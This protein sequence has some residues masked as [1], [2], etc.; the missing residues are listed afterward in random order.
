MEQMLVI[1]LVDVQVQETWGTVEFLEM[2][3]V[4]DDVRWRFSFCCS[5]GNWP[6]AGLSGA[7]ASLGIGASPFL[8]GL[9][10][11]RLSKGLVSASAVTRLHSSTC[12]FA[13]S[14]SSSIVSPSLSSHLFSFLEDTCTCA[15]RFSRSDFPNRINT[16][17]YC[18]QLLLRTHIVQLLLKL[19]HF[20]FGQDDVNLL[21]TLT[22]EWTGTDGHVLLT[23][24]A[25]GL[26]NYVFMFHQQLIFVSAV[27][28][29]S[30]W[31]LWSHIR[32]VI[33]FLF[34]FCSPDFKVHFLW[35]SVIW[36]SAIV[37]IVSWWRLSY[38]G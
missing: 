14:V 36:V 29:I 19:L 17:L 26:L 16:S 13:H 1:L 20:S 31:W 32:L 27:H 28:I 34:G 6:A 24:W 3:L 37:K 4:T 8:W 22:V 21:L 38:F 10:A 12:A 15:A 23:L 2:A 18:S 25:S 5:W 9:T 7:S 30:L 33:R 35:R 11:T